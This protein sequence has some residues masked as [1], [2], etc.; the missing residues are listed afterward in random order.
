R[1][2]ATFS[3]TDRP[4]PASPSRFPRLAISSWRMPRHWVSR[5]LPS[6]ADASP[7][8]PVWWAYPCLRSSARNGTTSSA[9]TCASHSVRNGNCC[10]EH[11]PSL[12]TSDPL[13]D[14]GFDTRLASRTATQPTEEQLSHFANRSSTHRGG[15]VV[16]GQANRQGH[17]E[18]RADTLLALH[19]ECAPV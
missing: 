5:M 12:P 10:S 6:S 4:R 17:G 3:P 19:V 7:S 1:R 18:H 9:R 15:E 13:G 2:S 8:L 11:P 14:A 16:V